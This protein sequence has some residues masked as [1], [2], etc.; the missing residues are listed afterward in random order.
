[1]ITDSVTRTPLRVYYCVSYQGMPC[2]PRTRRPDTA[3]WGTAR[4]R[5]SQPSTVAALRP[6]APPSRPPWSAPSPPP[7]TAGT[8]TTRPVIRHPTPAPEGITGGPSRDDLCRN[9]VRKPNFFYRDGAVRASGTTL[10]PEAHRDTQRAA[11]AIELRAVRSTRWPPR[12]RRPRWMGGTS[13]AW[14][15][16]PPS[17]GRRGPRRPDGRTTGQ[18]PR[19]AGRPDRER[20][21][22]TT[23]PHP[24]APT[25]A[26]EDWPP[27]IA[28]WW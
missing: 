1:M 5:P 9:L 19:R 26:P 23:A 8:A 4:R 6:N 24:P 22:L 20:E 15:A 25:V 27:S 14:R 3:A 16:G 11:P 13:R 7:A 12:P 17:S 2:P 28:R 18:H 10:T 21:V